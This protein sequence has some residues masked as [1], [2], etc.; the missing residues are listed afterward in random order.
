MRCDFEEEVHFPVFN[1]IL[2]L[3]C[4]SD[5]TQMSSITSLFQ[6]HLLAIDWHDNS[7]NTDFTESDQTESE[8]LQ[9]EETEK[10]GGTYW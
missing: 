3:S 10:A 5:L 2:F 9:T 8:L 4:A 6:M 7:Y 1:L